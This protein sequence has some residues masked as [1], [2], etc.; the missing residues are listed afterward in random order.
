[1]ATPDLK[2]QAQAMTTRPTTLNHFQALFGKYEMQ[3]AQAAPKKSVGATRAIAI[4]AQYYAS[5]PELH[6]CDVGS[7]IGAVLVSSAMGLNVQLREVY[8]IP[9]SG[10]IQLQIS[11]FGWI[12]LA[13]KSGMLKSLN[14]RCVY[15]GDGFDPDFETCKPNHK[16]GANYGDPDKVTHAYA[17]VETTDGGKSLEILTKRMI[18]R[19]RQKSPMQKQGIKG[20]WATDYDKMAIAKVIKQAL[21]MIPMEDEWR[22]YTFAD[23]SINSIESARDAVENASFEYPNTEGSAEVMPNDAPAQVVDDSDPL[24]AQLAKEQAAQGQLDL[25]GGAK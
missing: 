5:H 18:E 14:A 25:N 15:E 9:Y 4:C 19:L 13:K 24:A 6:A 8:F 10:K 7:M 16:M 20:P 2:A 23:E 1:M 17:V 12:K 11:Y 22:S 3:V 21:R